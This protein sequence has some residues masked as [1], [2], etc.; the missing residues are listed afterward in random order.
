MTVSDQGRAE[1]FNPEG[2]E[3]LVCLTIEH[4][5]ISPSIRVVN[6]TEAIVSNA[7]N[8]VDDQTFIAYPFDITWPDQ[9]EDSPPHAQLVID[10]V[11]LQIGKT[12]REMARTNRATVT[13]M[14]VRMDDYNNAEEIIPAMFLTNVVIDSLSIRGDLNV[15]DMTREPF[16]ARTFS[17]A[18]YPGLLR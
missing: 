15:E 16:P 3:F 2:D 8:G 13:L 10:N 7:E 9:R 17:P 1:L 12:L 11:D 6:N 14:A 4:E 5:E 18:E